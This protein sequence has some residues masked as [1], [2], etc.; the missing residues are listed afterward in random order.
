[1]TARPVT[2][3]TARVAFCTAMAA[4]LFAGG[5]AHAAPVVRAGAPA[6]RQQAD[7]GAQIDRQ[8]ALAEQV[9]AKFPAKLD[10]RARLAQAYLASGRF[11]S[12]AAT[13]E[14]AVALGDK[15]PSTALGMALAYVATGRNAEAI[16]LLGQ[17]RDSMPSSDYALALAL[18]GQP[19]QAVS[20][21][22]DAIGNGEKSAQARQNLAYAYAL[23]G[24][25]REARVIASQ[26]VPADQLDARLGQWAVMARSD[27]GKARVAELLGAPL[28]SDP[29]RPANLALA[30]APTAPQVAEVVSATDAAPQVASAVDADAAGVQELPALAQRTEN[31]PQFAQAAALPESPAAQ[32]APQPTAGAAPVAQLAQADAPVPATPPRRQFVSMPVVQD[33]SRQLEQRAPAQVAARPVHGQ[34]HAVAQTARG[35]THLVQLGAFSSAAQARRAWD[36]YTSRDPR[37]KDHEMH[38]SEAVVNGKR[39]WRVA[40]AGFDRVAARSL[41]TSPRGRGQGWFAYASDRVLAGTVPSA[42]R[43]RFA[44]S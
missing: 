9:V 26:D 39:Y 3:A 11:D 31:A 28:R 25:W 16:S 40:A 19:A 38:I 17:W 37:L 5:A 10:A 32:P 43:S 21:L 23:D 42:D 12:A 1:M 36:I 14:D 30:P 7:P 20:L 35:A 18:A 24:R 13:F 6:P 33:I 44:Q 4:A 15:T 34:G 41:C 8:V 22:T 29:G 2:T 27:A